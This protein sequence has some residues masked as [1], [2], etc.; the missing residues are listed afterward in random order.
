LKPLTAA[1]YDQVVFNRLRLFYIGYTVLPAPVLHHVNSTTFTVG[2]DDSGA[3]AFTLQYAP[4]YDPT[5]IGSAH[6][7]TSPHTVRKKQDKFCVL[8][9]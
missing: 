1:F 7:T 6:V 4:R 5:Q 8:F 2:F 3:S 9:F